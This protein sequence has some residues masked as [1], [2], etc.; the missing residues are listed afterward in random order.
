MIG[1]TMTNLFIAQGARWQH[2]RLDRCGVAGV[3]R[4]RVIEA[5]ARHRVPCEVRTGDDGIAARRGRDLSGE[6]PDRYL[7]RARAGWE[8]PA[9]GPARTMVQRWLEQET[10]AQVA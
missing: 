1:G 6:Q 10:D 9:A 5:A 8:G 2:P 7:A 3:T 4:E